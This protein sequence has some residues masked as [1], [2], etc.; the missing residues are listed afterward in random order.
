MKQEKLKFYSEDG[1]GLPHS[2]EYR[3]FQVG[4]C[5]REQAFE[6]P[7]HRGFRSIVAA[8]D[9]G[10]PGVAGAQGVVLSRKYSEMRL[11][12]LAGVGEALKRLG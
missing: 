10:Q 12:N 8:L 11:A 1:P 6:R 4:E 2:L 5:P 9:Y 3:Y 7:E